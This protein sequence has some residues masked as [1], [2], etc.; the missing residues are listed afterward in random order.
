MVFQPLSSEEFD[1]NVKEGIVIVDF[2]ATWCGPCKMISPVFAELSTKYTSIKF[3]KVDVDELE[4]VSA[5]AGIEAMPSFFVYKNGIK[6]D[7][8]VGA[9]SEKLE[10]LI[11]KYA[12]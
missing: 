7:E 12:N 11:K 2:T 10:K 4:E 8:L 3:L 6:V 5:K 1:N 9:S